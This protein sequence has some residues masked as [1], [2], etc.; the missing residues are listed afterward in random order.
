MGAALLGR[1]ATHGVARPAGTQC[2]GSSGGSQGRLAARGPLG[3][4]TAAPGDAHFVVRPQWAQRDSARPQ[5]PRNTTTKTTTTTTKTH[6][7][8]HTKTQPQEQLQ[9]PQ[10]QKTTT[11]AEPEARMEWYWWTDAAGRRLRNSARPVAHTPTDL[12]NATQRSSKGKAVGVAAVVAW[13]AA[14][15]RLACGCG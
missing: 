13:R 4:S 3:R 15:A 1:K 2:C 9:Q 14:A 7:D 10:Q 12:C 8:T 5:Q 6:T 11:M